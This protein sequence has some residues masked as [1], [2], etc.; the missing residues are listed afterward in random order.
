M[1]VLAC[2]RVGCNNIM[3]DTYVPHI[4]YICFECQK[5]FINF[6]INN[7]YIVNN[8][9]QVIEHLEQFMSKYKTSY[10][11]GMNVDEFF[12]KYTT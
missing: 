3:C 2:N 1:S 10:E 8:E 4:G 9:Y 7:G 5:E 12:K 11:S 6:L